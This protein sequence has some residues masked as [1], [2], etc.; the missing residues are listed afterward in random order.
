LA[1]Y[2]ANRQRL[3]GIANQSDGNDD[4]RAVLDSSGYLHPDFTHTLSPPSEAN[5]YDP[6]LLTDEPGPLLPDASNALPTY[7]EVFEDTDV[8]KVTLATTTLLYTVIPHEGH[9]KISGVRIPGHR[10]QVVNANI[11]GEWESTNNNSENTFSLRLQ[12]RGK[13]LR[14]W[15]CSLADRGNKIDCMLEE[16]GISLTGSWDGQKADVNVVS[17]FSG[18]PGKAQITLQGP[19]LHWQLTQPPDGEHY[20]VD[21]CLMER[22]TVKK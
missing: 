4:W 7:D 10:E 18:N 20:L 6:L 9:R 21:D 22:L 11:E 19:F 17:A 5:R 12:C 16:D 13:E 14:G 15:V 3:E 2:A 8:I 1:W